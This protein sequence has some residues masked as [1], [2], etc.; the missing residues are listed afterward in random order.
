MFPPFAT[1]WRLPLPLII[2]ID[3]AP[4][5]EGGNLHFGTCALTGCANL[6]A[7]VTGEHMTDG[8]VENAYSQWFGFNPLDPITD[9]GAALADVLTAWQTRGWSADFTMKPD[10][11][12]TLRASD[13]EAAIFAFGGA[14][15]WFMLPVTSDEPD[16]SDG[17]L[18][19]G[20]PGTLAHCMLE[21]GYD[22]GYVGLVSWGRVWTVS[23][24]WRDAY[25]RGGFGVLHPARM[26][27]EGV[28]Q[29]D[30]TAAP[31]V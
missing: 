20:T 16:F 30:E 11:A 28:V 10:G 9:H 27:P 18:D 23:R 21:V 19:A 26:L 4:W 3:D 24:R 31:G 17:A 25:W 6:H 29:I 15:S 2:T 14:Y 8:E 1:S 13:L 7:L 5:C 22:P 12:W